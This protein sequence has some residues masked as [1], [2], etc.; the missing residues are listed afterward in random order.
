MRKK[1][2]LMAGIAGFFTALFLLPTL[3][4][5]KILQIGYIVAGLIIGLP[6]LWMLA[7]VV[8]RFLSRWLSWIYQ[9]VKFIIVGFLNTA[10]DFG[11]LNFLSL[12]TGLT[13]GFIIGGVNVPGFVIAAT[14]SYF[15][16][17]FWVFAA[18]SEASAKEGRKTGYGDVFTFIIVIVS[19]AVINSG[20]VVLIS[21]YVHP[22]FSFSPERWLN[23][24]KVLATAIALAWNFLGFKFFVFSAK[25]AAPA[26]ASEAV[27]RGS[28]SGGKNI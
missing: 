22:L 4:N 9:F 20:I 3:K 5:V 1:D 8:G 15:W 6:L 2:F 16:N 13:S 12:Y 11:V 27:G 18:P 17:K 28:A 26:I 19:G 10:I 21:T 14:N 24:A 25:G 23:I 7:L